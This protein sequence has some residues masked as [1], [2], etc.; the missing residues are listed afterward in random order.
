M[1]QA[2]VLLFL[3]I[4]ISCLPKA[5]WAMEPKEGMEVGWWKLPPEIVAGDDDVCGMAWDGAELWVANYSYQKYNGKAYR[6]DIRTTE[7]AG[8]PGTMPRRP[9][10]TAISSIRRA[11]VSG[12]LQRCS[13]SPKTLSML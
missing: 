9:I 1:K 6:L 11:A 7:H 3:I 8:S 2:I 13:L 5:S 12:K 10:P 4:S